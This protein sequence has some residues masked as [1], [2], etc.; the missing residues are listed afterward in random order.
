MTSTT[1]EEEMNSAAKNRYDLALTN[2]K[3][4]NDSVVPAT[5]DLHAA[6]ALVQ[7]ILC[8]AHVLDGLDVSATI[9]TEDPIDVV[10][11]GN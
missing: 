11:R 1:E 2:L 5:R 9:R 3:V 4:V 6:S 7:A 10:N 8:L